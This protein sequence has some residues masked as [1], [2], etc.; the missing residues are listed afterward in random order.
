MCGAQ[1][2]NRGCG[3]ACSATMRRTSDSKSASSYTHDAFSGHG[4]ERFIALQLAGGFIAYAGAAPLHRSVTACWMLV[5]ASPTHPDV[6]PGSGPP[7][8]R[9]Q[10]KQVLM[11]MFVGL[12]Y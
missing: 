2:R 11:L 3:S 6:L 1:K 5:H 12:R 7:W 8:V 4:A 9:L 10:I